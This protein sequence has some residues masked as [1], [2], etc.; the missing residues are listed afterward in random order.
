MTTIQVTFFKNT[1][2]TCCPLGEVEIV[3]LKKVTFTDQTKV[4]LDEN[5]EDQD[6]DD[7]NTGCEEFR[8]GIQN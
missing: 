3:F 7:G 4:D 2:S 6:E 5:E 8:R 1:I